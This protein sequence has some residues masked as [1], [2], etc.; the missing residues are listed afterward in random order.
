MSQ[1]VSGIM[2]FTDIT[3]EH[4][5]RILK[6]LELQT[7][8]HFQIYSDMY[9]EYLHMLDNVFGL[10]IHA[11]KKII[12][13]PGITDPRLVQVFESMTRAATDQ[14]LTHLDNYGEFLQWYAKT[15]TQGTKAYDKYMHDIINGWTRILE[16][17]SKFTQG[18][19]SQEAGRM[20]QE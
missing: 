7:P 5:S 14:W 1:N 15:R 11:E 2:S 10:L 8:M 17:S 6:D 18:S 20:M 16:G 19:K 9:K 4:T 12:E 3:K 13:D